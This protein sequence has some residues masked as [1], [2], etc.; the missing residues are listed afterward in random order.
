MK[1][2]FL[3]SPPSTPANKTTGPDGIPARLLKTCVLA[4]CA[5]IS[6]ITPIFKS[7]DSRGS[8]NNYWPI[9]L[10]CCT[11]K[12]LEKIIHNKISEFNTKS[13]ISPTIW[14]SKKPIHF[15]AIINLFG[16][17]D[18]H[19]LQQR[20]SFTWISARHLTDTVPHNKLLMKLCHCDITGTLCKFFFCCLPP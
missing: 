13:I 2:F 7:G 20:T 9:S 17:G 11:S 10:L 16:H 15:E 3:L 19:C 12:V 6:Q 5:S 18:Q 4:I 8:I 1:R 14:F